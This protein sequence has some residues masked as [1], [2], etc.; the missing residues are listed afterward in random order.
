MVIMA[1]D[2][3]RDFLHKDAFMHDPLDLATTNPFL[4]FTRWITHFCA[5]TFVMLAGTSAYLIGLRKDMKDLSSFLIKR[6]LWLIL[7]EILV[8]TLMTTFDPLYHVIVLQVIWAIGASL[9]LLGLAVRL[10]YKAIFGIGL[11]ILLLHNLLDYPEAERQMKVGFLWDLLHS[12]YFKPYAYA[13]NRIVMLIYPLIPWVGIMMMGYCL[14]KLFE[15]AVTVEI[16][17][18]IFVRHRIWNDCFLRYRKNVQW[19]WR[20]TPLVFSK[21]CL[22]HILIFH[23]C[24]EISSFSHV[25]LR[26]PRARAHRPCF[27]GAC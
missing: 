1:L 9:L 8:V 12:G 19:L 6:G 24:S 4:Y 20:S 11:S 22:L 15:P 23:E 17:T 7:V 14:G 27:I 25:Y 5:P 26:N 21:K 16:E 10:P 13:P 3:T 2:H 18:Q